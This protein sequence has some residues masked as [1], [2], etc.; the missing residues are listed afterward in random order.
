[1]NREKAI[2]LLKVA[3]C[4]FYGHNSG[5]MAEAFEMAIDA[6]RE[7]PV[8]NIAGFDMPE[9]DRKWENIMEEMRNGL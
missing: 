9:L 6:L 8:K 5:E 3:R 2:E 7:S 4:A 1:M